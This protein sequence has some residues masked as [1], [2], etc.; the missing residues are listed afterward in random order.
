[1]LPQVHRGT[2]PGGLNLPY[3]TAWTDDGTLVACD[4]V[5]RL[6]RWRGRVVCVLGSSRNDLAQRLAEILLSLASFN[7]I[8]F[9]RFSSISLAFFFISSFFLLSL[10]SVL[11]RD[12]FNNRSKFV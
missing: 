8:D 2:V 6:Q 12:S 10:A 11:N 5:D 7:T 4:A 3:L 1:M 9:L